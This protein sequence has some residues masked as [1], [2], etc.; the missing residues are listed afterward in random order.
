MNKIDFKGDWTFNY[1]FSIFR[2][3]LC[4]GDYDGEPKYRDETKVKFFDRVDFEP[5]PQVEQLDTFNFI[6]ENQERLLDNLLEITSKEIFPTHK[7]YV[8]DE[9]QFFPE[10]NSINDLKRVYGLDEIFIHN[11]FK[12][13]QAYYTL[14]FNN[15]SPD[16][17]HGQHLTFHKHRLIDFSEG[18][19]TAKIMNDLGESLASTFKEY[20]KIS[21]K[22][23]QI[24]K[25]IYQ[26]PI[27]KYNKLK[28]WQI[29]SNEF[30]P[31]QL[32]HSNK[33]DLLKKY[34][35][36]ILPTLGNEEREIKYWL[37]LSEHHKMSETTEMLKMQLGKI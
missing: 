26:Y 18:Y 24:Q 13:G 14:V 19:D 12:D 21:Y 30:Y 1:I 22:N 7:Q 33:A 10:L 9:E 2:E 32:I 28:P 3:Y 11:E 20:N 29:D 23:S 8:D 27:P 4:F 25:L 17:E 36:D 35:E 31:I 6:V 5:E 16:G 15:F 37:Q 34:I